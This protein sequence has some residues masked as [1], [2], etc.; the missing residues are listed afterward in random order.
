MAAHSRSSF[1]S[2]PPRPRTAWDEYLQILGLTRSEQAELDSGT[3]TLSAFIDRTVREAATRAENAEEWHPEDAVDSFGYQILEAA[4][5]E[6]WDED[7]RWHRMPE[8]PGLTVAMLVNWAH[9]HERDKALEAERE[10]REWRAAD[11]PPPEP[12]AP[13]QEE[14]EY[15]PED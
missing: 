10:H 8:V 13:I 14:E 5:Q 6:D 4:E 3:I 11:P 15:D 2:P 7:R 9:E 1:Q 12:P